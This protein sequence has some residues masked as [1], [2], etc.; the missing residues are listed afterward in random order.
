M[1]DV[2]IKVFLFYYIDTV[3]ACYLIDLEVLVLWKIINFIF[4][5]AT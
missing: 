3:F 4:E 2:H 1:D 5:K